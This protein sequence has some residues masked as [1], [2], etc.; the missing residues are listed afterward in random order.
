LRYL[1][2]GVTE[3]EAEFSP[4]PEEWSVKEILAHLID[5]ECYSLHNIAELMIDGQREFSGGDG[6][7]RARLQVLLEVT[8]TIP[9]L[10]DRLA[11]TREEVISLLS[12][13]DKLKRRKGVLWGLAL[14]FLEYPNAH[15]RNHME[16]MKTV[17]AAARGE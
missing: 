7:T 9:D 10:L 11:Q 3:K 2:E 6:D 5:S 16:Q 4:R 12:K 14:N 1:L 15:E 8:P 17:I 13:A